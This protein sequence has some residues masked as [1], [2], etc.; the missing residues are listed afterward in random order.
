MNKRKVLALALAVCIIAILAC[1]TLAYFTDSENVTNKFYTASY[2][3]DDPV[4]DP[5]E[6]FSIVVF[7]TAPDGSETTEGIEYADILPGD[8]LDKDPTV[9][10]T[11]DYA[12]WVR[13]SVTLTNAAEWKAACATHG[14]ED[15]AEIF[16]GFNSAWERKA[17]EENTSED[18][19]TYVYYLKDALAPDAE[20]TLFERVTIP[21]ELTTAEFAKLSYFEL[22]IAGDAIQSANTGDSAFEAFEAHW[23]G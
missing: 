2:K 16:G 11:G 15:L 18:T 5:D 22:Q 20:S 19:L 9:R 10:N 17:I 12:A 13:L 3:P 1:G 8:V 4:P 21:E 6:L 23:K 7:E 14:I